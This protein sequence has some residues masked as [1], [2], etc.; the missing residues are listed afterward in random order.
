MRPAERSLPRAEAMYLVLQVP[1]ALLRGLGCLRRQS[2]FV[3]PVRSSHLA[4]LSQ[5]SLSTSTIVLE[6]RPEDLNIH[7]Y[8]VS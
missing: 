6:W 1:K 2:V 4:T 8:C 3:R 5:T 7:I